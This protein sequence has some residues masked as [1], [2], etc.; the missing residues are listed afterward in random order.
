MMGGVMQ[1]ISGGKTYTPGGDLGNWP[2]QTLETT[3]RF[4]IQVSPART[5]NVM[6]R[7]PDCRVIPGQLPCCLLVVDG[8]DDNPELLV[9]LLQ[10]VGFELQEARDEAE[11]NARWETWQPHL[12]W[13]DL[14]T[15]GIN[16]CEATQQIRVREQQRLGLAAA[17]ACS[18]SLLPSD[19]SCRRTRII[20]L[21]ASA[22]EYHP[23]A[24]NAGCDAAISKPLHKS[25]IR[26][27]PE[28]HLGLTFLIAPSVRHVSPTS[29][30]SLPGEPVFS[31][32]WASRFEQSILEDDLKALQ[33]LLEE[34]RPHQEILASRL[35]HLANQYE[36]E[37]LLSY[38]QKFRPWSGVDL[39]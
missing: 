5:W 33:S 24:L 26:S 11:A 18:R 9:T 38:M 27:A 37:R 7:S 39:I 29:V 16:A 30:P 6:E 32:I 17:V 8:K 22:L 13:M 23:I 4:T 10:P 28:T 3:F 20:A 34:L 1:V 2:E 12:I 21:S 25:D 31:A 19:F 35:L 15:L 14:R 36:F